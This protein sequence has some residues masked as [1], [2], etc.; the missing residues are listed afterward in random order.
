MKLKKFIKLILSILLCQTAGLIGS[1]FTFSAIPTWYANLNKPFFSPP[2][3]LF[4]PAWILLYTLMGISFFLIWEK[5]TKKNP[6]NYPIR[7]FLVH[8]GLNSLWSIIFFGLKNPALA[9][10]EIGVLWLIILEVIKVFRKI[11]SR[12]SIL[13]YP[14]LAW[15]SF[16]SLLNLTIWI[17]N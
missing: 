5:R 3:W 14:Y 9:F 16:A 15:V 4:A 2:N 6:Q 17:L 1:L 8:L 7:L 13:L 11:D 10:V 12:T